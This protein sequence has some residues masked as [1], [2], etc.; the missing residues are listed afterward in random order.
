MHNCG[1]VGL[2]PSTGSIPLTGHFPRINAISDPRTTIGPMARYVE[3]LALV[4]PII[5]G[6]DW[7]DAS[8]IPMSLGGWRE[9]DLKRLQVAGNQELIRSYRHHQ[10]DCGETRNKRSVDVESPRFRKPFFFSLSWC[11]VKQRHASCKCLPC[12]PEGCEMRY[13]VQPFTGQLLQW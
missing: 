12:F 4:M 8:V 3:D 6:M 1:I 13:E 7:Q 9:V 5:G 11:L 2:K 10:E